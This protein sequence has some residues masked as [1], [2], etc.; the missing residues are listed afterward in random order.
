MEIE[1]EE[2]EEIGVYGSKQ[3][4]SGETIVMT[5]TSTEY[6]RD[7]MEELLKELGAKVTGSVSSKTT[8]LLYGE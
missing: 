2:E 1:E 6:L 7:K 8:I 5:G 4:L 3:P